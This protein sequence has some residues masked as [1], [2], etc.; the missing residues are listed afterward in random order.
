MTPVEKGSKFMAQN[1]HKGKS[2]DSLFDLKRIL[3]LLRK[4]WYLFVISFP[5]CVGSV[6]IYHRYTVPVYQA[7]ATMLLKSGDQQSISRSELI[8]GFGLSPEVRNVE[9]QMF[10]IRSKKLVK[11]AIDR[12]NFGVTYVVEGVFKDTEL[13][14]SKPFIVEFDSLHPQL[15][16]VPINVNYISDDEVSVEVQADGGALFIFDGDKRAGSTGPIDL[17]EKIK[18]GE[19]LTTDQFSFRIIPNSNV[20]KEDASY[21]FVFKSHDQLANQYRSRLGVSSYREGS[22]IIFVTA[23]GTNHEK[24]TVFLDALCEVILEHNLEQKNNMATR[25]LAF[26]NSQLDNIADTL[27]KVQNSLLDYRRDNRFMGP[28]E[29]SQRLAEQ[30]FEAEKEVKMLEMQESYYEYLQNNLDDTADIEEY[31]LPAVNDENTSFINQLVLQLISYEEEKEML[32]SA[33]EKNNQYVRALESKINVTKENLVKGINQVLRSLDLEKQK[34]QRKINDIVVDMDQLPALEKTYLKID[35]SY[36]LND[37]IYTFLLQKQSETQIAKASNVPDNE[38]IDSASI[39]AVVSPTKRSNYQKGILLALILPAAFIALKEFLN[40]KIRNKDDVHFVAPDL[41]IV[42]TVVH[43]KAGVN[44][45]IHE[46][47]HSIISESFRALRTK[48]KY[49]NADKDVQVITLTSTNTGEG[50]TFCAENLASVFAISGK[51]TILLGFDLRKP[52]LTALFQL[53]DKP[54]LSNYLIN[55]ANID[56]IIYHTE[57]SNLFVV[58]AGPIPPNPSELLS[59]SGPKELFDYLRKHFDVIIVDSPP[60]GLVAD[61][62]MLIQESDYNLFVVR[63]NYTLREHM[64]LTIENLMDEDVSKIGILMNDISLAEKGY[65]YYSAEYYSEHYSS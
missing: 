25:S 19:W 31:M 53:I 29:F 62:R 45:V 61:A 28:S 36:K 48:L 56:D 8:E 18:M 39:S 22:S 49:M 13:Y 4:N 46:H 5:L 26:I 50:K 38:I 15:L 32:Y 7:R 51:K 47:P 17:Y 55:E 44:N 54:G 52:R 41:S 3:F 11:K 24:L 42:G 33:A 21:H 59:G 35:R 2:N 14:Y 10:V 12:L 6:Y 27:D 57:Y 43:N 40:T 34:Y 1:A 64:A 20:F 58:P 60:I 63:A 23:T 37:A 16:N 9:N 65:G 30:Y